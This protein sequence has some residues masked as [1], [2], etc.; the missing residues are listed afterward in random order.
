MGR[1]AFPELNEKDWYSICEEYIH[2]PRERIAIKK[3]VDERRKHLKRANDEYKTG[4]A[5]DTALQKLQEL[6]NAN[7]L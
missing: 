6:M 7:R 1:S 5:K 4:T 2:N 3:I